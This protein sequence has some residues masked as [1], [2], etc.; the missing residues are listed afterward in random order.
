MTVKDCL[1]VSKNARLIFKRVLLF[2]FFLLFFSL[3]NIHFFNLI[4]GQ[5]GVVRRSNSFLSYDGSYFIFRSYGN[6]LCSFSVL[7]PL[8][9]Y[10]S[11][12]SLMFLISTVSSHIM[13][14]TPRRADFTKLSVRLNRASFHHAVNKKRL[15][16]R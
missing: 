13:C 12:V 15:C 9:Y 10:F 11:L 14:R 7:Y 5:V 8:V 4:Y 6:A 1:P 3:A 16:H 2:I